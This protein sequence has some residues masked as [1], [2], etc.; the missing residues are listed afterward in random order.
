MLVRRNMAMPRNE[1]NCLL[2]QMKDSYYLNL[3]LP[4]VLSFERNMFLFSLD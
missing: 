2:V 3:C 4:T 1:K